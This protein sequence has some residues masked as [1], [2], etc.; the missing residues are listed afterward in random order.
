MYL[1]HFHLQEFPFREETDPDIFFQGGDRERVVR[2]LLA[3]IEKGTAFLRV[4]GDEGSGKTLFC[5]VVARRLGDRWETV[6][7]AD[8][9][10]SFVDLMKNVIGELGGRVD[11]NAARQQ[12]VTTLR[13]LVTEKG[14]AGKKGVLLLIDE[15]EKIFQATLESLVRLPGELGP[16]NGLRIVL[17][18]RP[19]LDANLKRIAR[20]CT[21]IEVVDGYGLPP[22]SREETAEYLHYRQQ[23]VTEEGDDLGPIFSADAASAVYDKAGG[24]IRKTNRLAHKA[25]ERACKAN[26]VLVSSEHVSSP[27]EVDRRVK[28]GIFA[29]LATGFDLD[30]LREKRWLVGGIG[31]VLTLLI[32]L[33]YLLPGNKDGERHPPLPDD[34]E[35]AGSSLQQASPAPSR[36]EEDLADRGKENQPGKDGDHVS[37]QP[38][39]A[40]DAAVTAVPDKAGVP[41]ASAIDVDAIY[42]ERLRASAAW[43]AGAYRGSYTIQ[44]MM[45]AS[46]SAEKNARA[47]FHDQEMRAV[48]DNI[49]ILR[50][51][52]SPPTVFFFFGSY[53]SLDK[54]RNARNHLPLFLR[55]HHPYAI[56]ISNALKK[57]ED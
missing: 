51:K 11:E 29:G 47:L 36:P 48:K 57:M 35:I 13:Q 49:F 37:P 53:D 44:I 1:E 17:V 28:K 54:A 56:S 55:K 24:N 31:A 50:K 23:A 34:Q 41:T 10:G 42:D 52:T 16:E 45:L 18:A 20:Y 46:D 19:E 22:L 5:A 30:L 12:I 14:K 21:D 25:M 27:R 33:A 3:D 39:T 2:A 6:Y 38:H 15:A 8:P 26:S 40:D 43:L 9:V 32:L 7:L 4:M